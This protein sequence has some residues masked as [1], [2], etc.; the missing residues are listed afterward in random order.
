MSDDSPPDN[1]ICD[2]SMNPRQTTEHPFGRLVRLN[3]DPACPAHG[4]PR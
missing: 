1:C 4:N 2:W 3:T